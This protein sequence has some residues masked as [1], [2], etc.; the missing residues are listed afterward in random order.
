[1]KNRGLLVPSLLLLLACSTNSAPNDAPPPA[2][3]AQP[4]RDAGPDPRSAQYRGYEAM[5]EILRSRLVA[6]PA[7]FALSS[8]LDAPGADAGSGVGAN[9]AQLVGAWSGKGT[10][11]SFQNGTPNAMS[12]LIWRVAFLGF[13]KDVAALCPGSSAPRTVANLEIRADLAA[14]VQSICAWPVASAR[15]EA[16]LHAFWN[17]LTAFD[18]PQSEYEAWRDH[19]LGPTY[20]TATGETV[21]P[22]MVTA[23][24]LNPYVLLQP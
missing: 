15:D 2:P 13:G 4:A 24:M 7:S 8:Y 18:A 9:L 3:T 1:M 17:G 22:F 21:I 23:A 20:A 11:N 16:V 6:K 12:F 19:F 14:V 5:N 10:L